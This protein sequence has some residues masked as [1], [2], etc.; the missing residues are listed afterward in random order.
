M[1]A[2][3][4][5]VKMANLKKNIGFQTLYQ[6]LET[7]LPLITSPYLSRVLGAEQ[8]GIFSY[9]QSIVNYFT[10]FAMLGLNNYG[11]R[12]I[13]AAGEDIEKRS[14]DFWSIYA[15]Q[16]I[17]SF[18]AL[19]GYLSYL[20]FLCK[21]NLT[22]GVIQGLAILACFLNINW[23]FFGLEKFSITVTRNAIIR[24]CTVV[25]ILTL[26]KKQSDLWIYA[27]VM[28]ASTFLSQAV[29]WFYVPRAIKLA[30]VTMKDVTSHI[31]SVLILFVPVAAMSVYHVMDKTMLG[32]LST[33]EQSGFYYNADK[34]INIP[35][36]I[37][38]GIGTVMLPRV[39]AL[40]A[41]NRKE[42]ADNLF[43]RSM[44]GSVLAAS[45]LAFGIAAIAKEFTP[46]FFGS[47]YEPCINLIIVLA[48]VLVIKGV[49][50]S[51]RFQY[52]IPRK[53]DKIYIS[54]VFAGMAINLIINLLAIPPL[55]ALGAV[56]GTLVA[57]LA[58]CICQLCCIR[59]HID[60]RNALTNS[61]LY[62][63]FGVTMFG[64]VRLI[65]DHLDGSL[66]V[67]IFEIGVGASTYVILT[68]FYFALSDKKDW[69][70]RL[71]ADKD[72]TDKDYKNEK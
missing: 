7:C 60:F 64:T 58:A 28:V 9:T 32:V 66:V 70:R 24:V 15:I 17:S 26:V 19:S 68:L 6:I 46:F 37:I 2:A 69:I 34:V 55:G 67:L 30:R 65:G 4:G 40:I 62:V 44:E 29:L 57:E 38:S 51:V 18:I 39:S 63:I 25:L 72:C 45:A 27:L 35:A 8:L 43:L 21:E 54:S 16:F 61:L 5:R 50:F 47:G 1:D 71:F 23:L 56:I 14:K 13:A 52:L 49:A 53:M 36:G 31:K 12:C 22:I 42:D 11:T 59:K 33:Y 3:R 20:F 10:L 41:Q 48:P